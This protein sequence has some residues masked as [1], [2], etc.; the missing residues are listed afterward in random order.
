MF[1]VVTHRQ[2]W[3]TL[4][5]VVACDLKN[6]VDWEVITSYYTREAAVNACN[7]LDKVARELKGNG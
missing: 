4:Y 3:R 5:Y 2:S 7:A 1:K 6:E